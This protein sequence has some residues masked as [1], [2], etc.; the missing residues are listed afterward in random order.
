MGWLTTIFNVLKLIPTL[1]EAVKKIWDGVAAFFAQ[2]NREGKKKELDHAIK[3]AQ[4]TKDTSKIDQLFG[5]G[6]KPPNS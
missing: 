4:E 5:G 2:Q 6:R 1:L 3:Q